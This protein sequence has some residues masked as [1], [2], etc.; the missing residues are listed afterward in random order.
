[1]FVTLA[2]LIFCSTVVYIYLRVEP[3][4][5]KVL[6]LAEQKQSSSGASAP[7]NDDPMPQYLW[8]NAMSESE[9]WAREDALKRYRQLYEEHDNDWKKVSMI[10]TPET[11]D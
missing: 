4:A 1:M 2:T 9:Q 7:K 8:I 6:D 11:A 3:I 5:R 10:V